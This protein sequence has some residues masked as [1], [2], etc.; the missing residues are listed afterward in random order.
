MPTPMEGR[1][2]RRGDATPVSGGVSDPSR[3][4]VDTEG[5]AVPIQDDLA[6]EIVTLLALNRDKI[7]LRFQSGQ[8][9]ELDEAA[10]RRMITDIRQRLGIRPFFKGS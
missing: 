4:L 9:D 8:L 3:F 5:S 1:S 10:K 7:D 6:R 2:T